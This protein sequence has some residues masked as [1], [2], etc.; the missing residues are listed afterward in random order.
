MF[1][2]GVLVITAA[3]LIVLAQW[4]AR[5]SACI[6]PRC[7]CIFTLS[8][9]KDLVSPQGFFIHVVPAADHVQGFSGEMC[10]CK[11]MQDSLFVGRIINRIRIFRGVT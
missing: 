6:C 1:H 10:F 7:N 4:H 8:A 11:K 3:I 5:T 2:V 9:L